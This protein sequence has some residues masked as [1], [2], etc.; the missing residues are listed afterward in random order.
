M[1]FFFP[2]FLVYLIGC[3]MLLR[4]LEKSLIILYA[5]PD[6][7]V[8]T[9]LPSLLPG[10]LLPPLVRGYTCSYTTGQYWGHLEGEPGDG[11]AIVQTGY[12]EVVIIVEDRM[13]CM[14]NGQTGWDTIAR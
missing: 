7:Q 10:F 8:Q 3:G 5:L 6:T 12:Q 14:R 9:M 11:P 2:A 13:R 1:T 4:S